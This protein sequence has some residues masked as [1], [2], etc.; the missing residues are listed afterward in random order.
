MAGGLLPEITFELSFE[1]P[2]FVAEHIAFWCSRLGVQWM[3]FLWYLTSFSRIGEI[4]SRKTK[5]KAV[6]CILKATN[7]NRNINS[8]NSLIELVE[9]VIQIYI[10]V[11][12]VLRISIAFSNLILMVCKLYG[13]Y[14]IAMNVLH[15]N[16]H[17]YSISNKTRNF[18]NNCRCRIN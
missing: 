14:S 4:D 9:I 5:A 17:I 1:F 16:L 6:P 2:G 3:G 10:L 15:V 7:V 8:S 13:V 18:G 12:R 11:W